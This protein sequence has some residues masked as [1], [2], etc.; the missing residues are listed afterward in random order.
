M[1]L[2]ERNGSRLVLSPRSCA[3]A[4]RHA[5]VPCRSTPRANHPTAVKPSRNTSRPTT[6]SAI[7]AR[8]PSETTSTAPSPLARRR[9]TSL[10][11]RVR[12]AGPRVALVAWHLAASISDHADALKGTSGPVK[13]AKKEAKPA[14]AATKKTET[15]TEKKPAAPKKAA[16]PVSTALYTCSFAS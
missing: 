11:Q 8:R 16:A 15:K 4:S 6:R 2:K 10:S 5:S 14:A 9:A 12:S 13:L 7:S 3:V 1:Q